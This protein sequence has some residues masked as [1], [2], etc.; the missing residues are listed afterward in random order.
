MQ[1]NQPHVATRML[2]IGLL[3]AAASISRAASGDE[4]LRVHIISGSKEY[5]SNQTMPAWASRL[6]KRFNLQCTISKTTDRSK[7]LDNLTALA[8]ADLLVVFCRRLELKDAN[9]QPIQQYLDS[10]RPILGIRTASHAFNRNAPEFDVKILG[11][12]YVG[13]YDAEPNIHIK[14]ASGA[15]DHPILDGVDAWSRS[16][17]LYKNRRFADATRKLLIG[18]GDGRQEPVA[19]INTANNRRVF[20]TPMGVPEDFDNAQ[21]RRLLHNAVEWTTH[22]E[23]D[24]R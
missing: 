3:L 18:H 13:H 21:F 2:A 11:A 9:W 17:K 6:E 7:T 19:W 5:K 12:D 10:G 4:P 22:R 1:R 8:D 23:L 14:P 16:G 15:N 20:Y 24:T